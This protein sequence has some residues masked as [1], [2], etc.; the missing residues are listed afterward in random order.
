MLLCDLKNILK[1]EC[2]KRHLNIKNV[3]IKEVGYGKE[4]ENWM[5]VRGGNRV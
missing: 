1:E 5:V 3:F 2:L 4:G